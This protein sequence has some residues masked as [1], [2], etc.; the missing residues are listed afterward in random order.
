MDQTVL[1][2]E[3]VAVGQLLETKSD[4]KELYHANSAGRQ[5][6]KIDKQS[7]FAKRR[8]VFFNIMLIMT[9]DMLFWD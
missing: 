3:L 8:E 7:P 9:C 4:D 1:T 2:S 6:Q 5:R